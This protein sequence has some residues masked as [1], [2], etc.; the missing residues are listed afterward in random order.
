M[1]DIEIKYYRLLNKYNELEYGNGTG[2]KLRSFASFCILFSLAVIMNIALLILS[3]I[4]ESP[5]LLE[6]WI[7]FILL[8]IIPLIF[9]F[10]ENAKSRKLL[11]ELIKMKNDNQELLSSSVLFLEDNFKVL[12]DQEYS[13]TKDEKRCVTTLIY[14]KNDKVLKIVYK[15]IFGLNFLTAFLNDVSLRKICK[16]NKEL[17]C[18][19]GN[20]FYQDELVLIKQYI[21]KFLN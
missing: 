17:K 5:V 8:S 6:I 7:L 9:Y 4:E 10:F 1:S 14:E 21:N 16:D 20:I 11:N 15:K 18:W 13:F 3:I 19:V 12:I 2:S